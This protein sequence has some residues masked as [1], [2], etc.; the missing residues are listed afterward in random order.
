M[1]KLMLIFFFWIFYFPFTFSQA[2]QD[3]ELFTKPNGENI[4][5]GYGGALKSRFN[6]HGEILKSFE[7]EKKFSG[8]HC[9]A[10]N[11]D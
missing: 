5:I 8:Y 10:F 9:I 3:P 6:S 1:P 4:G 11:V 2:L 7:P